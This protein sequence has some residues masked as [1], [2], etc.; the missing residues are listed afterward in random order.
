MAEVSFRN[1]AEKSFTQMSSRFEDNI[2][3][4]LQLPLFFF[5]HSLFISKMIFLL[6][7]LVSSN[8]Y[9]Y[10]QYFPKNAPWEDE[11]EMSHYENS[12]QIEFSSIAPIQNETLSPA[13]PKQD[14]TN[15]TMMPSDFNFQ[16]PCNLHSVQL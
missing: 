12:P 6:F 3:N 15:S 5:D 9:Y 13:F 8:A 4:C 11:L 16:V 2:N 7:L 1:F 10:D 14:N